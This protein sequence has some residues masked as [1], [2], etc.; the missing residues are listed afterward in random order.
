MQAVEPQNLASLALALGARADLATVELAGRT[1]M[2]A[3]GARRMRCIVGHAA[4]IAVKRVRR[5]WRNRAALSPCRKT[6]RRNNW[7]VGYSARHGRHK[8]A[9]SV[10]ATGGPERD[11]RMSRVAKGADCKSAGYAFVGSSPTS[12]TSL[13]PTSRLLVFSFAGH[14]GLRRKFAA[15]AEHKRSAASLLCG[16]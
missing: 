2:R 1:A 3:L 11:G 15:P 14:F 5:Q 12:P 16:E 8:S 7:P 4:L 13:L 6:C 9:R 10:D